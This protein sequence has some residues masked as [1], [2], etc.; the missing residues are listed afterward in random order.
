M[1]AVKDALPSVR[2]VLIRTNG[3][4]STTWMVLASPFG[5]RWDPAKDIKSYCLILTNAPLLFQGITIHLQRGSSREGYCGCL[6]QW[7]CS[8]K[9]TLWIIGKLTTTSCFRH[10][11]LQNRGYQYQNNKK[12][13]MTQTIFLEWMRD[14]DRSIANHKILLILENCSAHFPLDDLPQRITLCS[15][16]STIF[17]PTWPIGYSLVTKESFKISRHT[18]SA[19]LSVYAFRISTMM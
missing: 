19:A 6:L 13:W 1:V 2:D 14:F 12:A 8:D 18:T 3:R 9:M 16:T 11:K 5:C 10:V 17:R 15:T 4:I 7:W